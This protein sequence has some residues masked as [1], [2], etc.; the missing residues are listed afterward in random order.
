MRLETYLNALV[1]VE[2]RMTSIESGYPFK[3]MESLIKRNRQYRAFRA[4]ILRMDA[5]KD[6]LLIT[7]AELAYQNDIVATQSEYDLIGPG[8]EFADKEDWIESWLYG[9]KLWREAD[10]D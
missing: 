10:N 9:L 7:A 4:R 1:L 5:E 6:E 8:N 3:N 2:K